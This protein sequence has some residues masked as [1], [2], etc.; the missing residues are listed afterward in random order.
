MCASREML[1]MGSGS[2]QSLV[3]GPLILV[4]ICQK[5]AQDAPSFRALGS[6]N[7]PQAGLGGNQ[8]IWQWQQQSVCVPRGVRGTMGAAQLQTP[9]LCHS[10]R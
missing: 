8:S 7:E 5:S 4:K 1:A 10:L 6:G 2:S 3:S 9:P